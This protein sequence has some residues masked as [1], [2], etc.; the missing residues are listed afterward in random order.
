MEKGKNPEK[1]KFG[2][3]NYL[4]LQV[5]EMEVKIDGKTEK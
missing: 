3:Q 4:L 1:D 2:K 5:H